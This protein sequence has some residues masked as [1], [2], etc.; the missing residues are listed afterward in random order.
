VLAT[1]RLL[2]NL[3]VKIWLINLKGTQR[4]WYS[5]FCHYS[6]CLPQN[7]LRA[8]VTCVFIGTP[9]VLRALPCMHR[10]SEGRQA[11]IQ[12]HAVGEDAQRPS[13]RLAII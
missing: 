3:F 8:N 4:C 10:C 11:C 7:G 5:H 6:L 2:A 1:N 13:W 9:S 12:P